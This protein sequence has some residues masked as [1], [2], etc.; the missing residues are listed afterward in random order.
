[1]SRLT[2]VSVVVSIFTL[3]IST[4]MS[5]LVRILMKMAQNPNQTLSK[6]NPKIIQIA[7]SS[8]ITKSPFNMWVQ[9]HL[10]MLFSLFMLEICHL[11][12]K[13]ITNTSKL[14]TS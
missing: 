14:W 2:K 13:Q 11:M 7:I 10:V 8:I 3:A 4:L 9:I 6:P 5:F 12:L 1:M